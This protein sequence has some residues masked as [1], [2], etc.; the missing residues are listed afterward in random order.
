MS[1]IIDE[2]T[3]SLMIEEGFRA[4]A[5]HDTAVPPRLT[6]GFGRNID[7]EGGGLGISED[8][9][10]LMLRNDIDRS[11]QECSKFYWFDRQPDRV[12]RVLIELCF[13]MGYPALSGFNRMLSA[14]SAD[15]Y[16][17]AADELLDSKFAVQ[18]PHRA[19]RLSDRLRG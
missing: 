6:I 2:I 16:S 13:Q 3:A 15:N 8:E 1:D 11:V 17:T 10:E 19:K 5:Y 18:V 4:H 12:K 9:A 7:R 14:L